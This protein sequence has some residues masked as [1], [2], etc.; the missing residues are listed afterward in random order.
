MFTL[1]LN[2]VDNI[3]EL[4]EEGNTTIYEFDSKYDTIQINDK[5]VLMIESIVRR[6]CFKASKILPNEVHFEP[7]SFEKFFKETV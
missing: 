6:K 1:K 5:F 2:I 3:I 7:S 4:R